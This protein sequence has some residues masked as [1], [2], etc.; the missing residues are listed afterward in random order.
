MWRDE[1][2]EALTNYIGKFTAD[3]EER[4]AEDGSV[5]YLDTLDAEKEPDAYGADVLAASE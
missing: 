1:F 5:Y 4:K 2:M 3:P